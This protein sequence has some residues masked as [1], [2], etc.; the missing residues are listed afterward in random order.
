MAFN[1]TFFSGPDGREIFEQQLQQ[2]MILGTVPP[3][4]DANYARALYNDVASEYNK[5]V[6][7]FQ[8]DMP[9]IT[10]F[11][12]LGRG[13]AVLDLGC[14]TG[15]VSFAAQEAMEGTGYLVGV[16][17]AEKTLEVAQGIAVSRGITNIEWERGDISDAAFIASLHSRYPQGFDRIFCIETFDLVQD[18]LSALKLWITLLSDHGFLILDKQSPTFDIDVFES[19]LLPHT[20]PQFQVKRC[21]IADN[22]TYA[23]ISHEIDALPAHL[24]PQLNPQVYMRKR[25]YKEYP[26][27]SSRLEEL[28]GQTWAK[29][30]PNTAIPRKE[31]L[32]FKEGHVDEDEQRCEGSAFWGMKRAKML[33]ALAPSGRQKYLG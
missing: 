9:D 28:A 10:A 17:V 32:K 16:D 25:M 1:I 23:E 7:F 13:M 14:A 18:N 22:Q 31:L 21:R 29:Q 20:S 12:K 15:M 11:A 19:A 24:G 2:H 8:K 4:W 3:P 26:C 33:V 30:H 27:I 6:Q 5:S